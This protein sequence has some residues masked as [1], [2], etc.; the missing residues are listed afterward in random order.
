MAAGGGGRDGL[1]DERRGLFGR[2]AMGREDG[3]DAD[4]IGWG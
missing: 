1:E 2:C 4:V 3:V